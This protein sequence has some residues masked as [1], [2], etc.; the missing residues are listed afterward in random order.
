M[1]VRNSEEHT[2]NKGNQKDQP[3][4]ERYFSSFIKIETKIWTKS[5]WK[6]KN[7]KCQC[8]I[9]STYLQTR[10]LSKFCMCMLSLVSDVSPCK[11]QLI[12]NCVLL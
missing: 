2:Q 4:L 6:Q 8:T 5:T 3:Q 11:A 10:P 1:T 7:K 9:Y 12:L